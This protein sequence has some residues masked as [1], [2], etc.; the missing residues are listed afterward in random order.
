MQN[1]Q[2]D[3]RAKVRI[4]NLKMGLPLDIPIRGPGNTTAGM[5]RVPAM[6]DAH[7][8]FVDT[9][10]LDAVTLNRIRYHYDWRPTDPKNYGK[11]REELTGSQ[12]LEVGLLRITV[13]PP[14]KP[15]SGPE[16]GEGEGGK[17][18]GS[19]GGQKPS[20]PKSQAA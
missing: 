15:K 18:G 8:N 20:T 9:D 7:Q 4:E 13:L 17:A 11:K 16:G 2:Q 1:A 19:G 3:A 12:I 5:V 14:S 10:Q 6:D